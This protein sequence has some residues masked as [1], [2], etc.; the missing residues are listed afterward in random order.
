[1]SRCRLP[2]IGMRNTFLM[3]LIAP[4]GL[5]ACSKM[6][7]GPATTQIPTAPTTVQTP[8]PSDPSDTAAA[9]AKTNAKAACEYLK[10]A[11]SQL[12]L[13]DKSIDQAVAFAQSGV[14]STLNASAHDPKYSKLRANA[15]QFLVEVVRQQ[16]QLRVSRRVVE[17]FKYPASYRDAVKTV[18]ADCS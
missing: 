15:D 11:I 7:A 17:A 8:L 5:V 14:D 1:V 3:L 13:D 6:S 18:K 9:A 12:S 4:L 16:V 10:A 2:D